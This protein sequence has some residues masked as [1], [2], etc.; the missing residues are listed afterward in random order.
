ML[1]TYLKTAWRNI[2]RGKLYS[3]LNVLGLAMGMAVALLIGLWMHYQLSYDR[4]VPGYEQAYQVRFNYSDNG[5]IRNQ[6]EV[7]LPLGDALKK[8]IPE[9]AH[10]AAA[11]DIGQQVMVVKDKRIYGDVLYAGEEFLQVFPLPLVGGD[12]ATA[13]KGA[14]PSVV[15]TESMA[16]SLFGKEDALNKIVRF[17]SAPLKVTAVVR[18]MPRNNSFHFDVLLPF[19]DFAQ[20]PGI[21]Q[22]LTNWNDA[23]FQLYVSLRPGADAV[24]AKAKARQLVRQYA[25]QSYTTF[26]REAMLFP[27]KDWH[28][29][30]SFKDG[31]PQGGLIDYV[32]MFSIVGI[33]VLLIAC[34]NFMN[35]ST[36][37]SERRAREVGV[38]KVMGSLR[39]QLI[40]QFLVESLLLT[41]LAF[42][43]SLVLVQAV[44]PAFDALTGDAIRV[45]Y[46]SG[47]FWLILLSL[48]LVTG[49]LAGSRPAFYLSSFQ[50]VKVLKAVVR[51][52]KA[53][54]LPRKALVVLQFTC[55]IALIISTI[56]VY[57]QIQY[58][59]DRP[60]GYDP[61]R[62]IVSR[63]HSDAFAAFKQEVMGSGVV[64]NLT[65]S[66]NLQTDPHEQLT[67]DNWPGRLPNEPLSLAV[68]AVGDADYFRT[69]GIAF[70][71]G[72]NFKGVEAAD[73]SSVII[74]ETAVRRMRL[75]QPLNQYLHCSFHG[76]PHRLRIVGVVKDAL[77]QNPFAAA[78]PSMF[79]FRPSWSWQYTMRLAPTVSTSM[80]L[81][82]LKTI[83]EKYQP[84]HPF[85]YSFVDETY[86]SKLATEMLIGRLA[87]VFAALAIFISCLGL[88]GLAAYTAEQRTREIGIRKVLGA[89]VSQ[90]LMLLSAD[91]I[92]LVGISCAIAAPLAY[93]FLHQ[94]LVGYYYRITIS[95]VVFVAAA[96]LALVITTITV[97]FQSVRSAMM[98]PVSA[99]R[100]E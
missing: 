15:I 20:D 68:N 47:Y 41:G 34:I 84:D 3:L 93:Y 11:F 89:S 35:L 81:A 43:F 48:V 12:P 28:L 21:K 80:A 75:K 88:L 36:A 59:K 90:V 49:L 27:L 56:I 65:R 64:S 6:A 54:S 83:S 92:L 79:L 29:Y 77:T 69:L 45:P 76:A 96:V 97:G 13:L 61:N 23:Y 58:A 91:F 62:L 55:S 67:I 71:K 53:A 70:A 78:E 85:A 7:C 5:V 4:F 31:Q 66:A 44:L 42:L 73:S 60:R 26:H 40:L 10:A 38:R 37:R 30:T 2:V 57:Q 24:R 98:N 74:N 33:L 99:L 46:G 50:P 100:S 14:S 87:G 51:I 32:R 8:D 94:W 63:A 82:K 95:P 86:A 18:D 17:G 52:G 16:R 25:P 9:V 72:D 1:I 22:A 19:S 39:G